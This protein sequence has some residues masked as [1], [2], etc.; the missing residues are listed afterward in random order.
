MSGAIEFERDGKRW[1][2][3]AEHTQNNLYNRYADFTDLTL[4]GFM[5]DRCAHMVGKYRCEKLSGHRD[6][7]R[8]TSNLLLSRV[9]LDDEIDEDPLPD[10]NYAY[11]IA[12][13]LA[14][15]VMEAHIASLNAVQIASVATRYLGGIGKKP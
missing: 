14:E 15:H 3:T 9:V 4:A 13:D 7:H 1:V 10:E 2:L 11:N 6:C 5:R 12:R 8:V